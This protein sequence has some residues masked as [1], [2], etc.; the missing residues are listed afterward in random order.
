MI[1]NTLIEENV[2]KIHED[3]AFVMTCFREV[4]R[5]LGEDDLAEQLP[6]GEDGAPSGAGADPRRTAQGYSMAFQLLSM[7]E[8]NA[9]V[10]QRRTAE[11]DGTLA[12]IS[13]LWQQN[14]KR[15]KERGLSGEQIADTLEDVRVEPVLT[16]H[17]TEAKRATV[18]EHH[19]RIYLLLVDR[20]NTV[21]TPSEREAIRES[22][23]TEL[24]RLWRT[25]E[26]YLEKPDLASERRN[27]IHY[28]RNVFPDVLPELD[29]RLRVAWDGMDF[30]PSLLDDPD[31]LPTLRFGNWVGGDRDGHPLVT[32]AVTEETLAELRTNALQLLREQLTELTRRLSLS[33]F[34]QPGLK[35]WRTRWAQRDGARWSEIPTS[36]GG[37]S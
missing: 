26:I 32:A 7:V 2:A 30:A 11:R 31:R 5:D 22:L 1:P 35:K 28:L 10:Q 13:G 6:W 9:A 23:K 29:R 18:L 33:E 36:R 19:R 20:E 21:W 3:L 34:L 37:S 24:E 8:E 14:L 4:L 16:A 17:P 27:A 12:D 15:L 25:G